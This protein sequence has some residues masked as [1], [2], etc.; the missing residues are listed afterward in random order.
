[1]KLNTRLTKIGFSNMNFDEEIHGSA[2]GRIISESRAIRE[3][4]VK[5]IVFDYRTF[6]DMCQAI[7]NERCRLNILKLRGI[8]INEIEGKIIQ[9]ILMKN[10]QIHT[11]DLSE[12]KTED[13]ANF[14]FF[15]EKM[16]QFCNIRYL[17]LE[18]MN[19]DLSHNLEQLGEALA[20]NVKLEVLVL[21]EN[22]L[23]WNAYQN[24]WACLMPNKTILKLNI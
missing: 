19:P 5:D 17:T 24:F 8:L 10:K 9:F 14:E 18:R 12:C 16:G 20:E 4:D 21:R 1:M 7:L 13:P 11:L 15:L 6:Y 23:K 2:V 3:L 22:R